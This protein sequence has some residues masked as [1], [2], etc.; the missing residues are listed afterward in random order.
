MPSQ[1]SFSIG[2]DG[3]RIVPLE[4]GLAGHNGFVKELRLRPPTYRDFMDLGDPTTLIVSANAMVPHDDLDTIRSYAE[5]LCDSD[6]LLM[7]KLTLRDAM[8]L[9]DAVKS[10]FSAGSANASTTSPTI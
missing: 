3:A 8:A 2:P 4:K 9:R 1:A 10:F 7:E 5:R 6:P